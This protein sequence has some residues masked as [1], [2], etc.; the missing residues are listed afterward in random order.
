[1]TLSLGVSST[2]FASGIPVVD[3]AGLAQM[4]MDAAESASQFQQQ[5]TQMRQ[6]YNTAMAHKSL[7][8]DL[9]KG[10]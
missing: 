10:N 1:M 8:E 4:V 7:V 2:S 3:V 5:M 9:E 6:A